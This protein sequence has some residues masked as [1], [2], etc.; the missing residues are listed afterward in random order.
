MEIEVIHDV[1]TILFNYRALPMLTK[2]MLLRISS[3][4][5]QSLWN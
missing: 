4:L 1:D 3:E 5:C 2:F